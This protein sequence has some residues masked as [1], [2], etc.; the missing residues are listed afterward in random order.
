MSYNIIILVKFVVARSRHT[1]IVFQLRF[2]ANLINKLKF[3]SLF[4][5]AT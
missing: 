4:H 1:E 5:V 2:V 3:N